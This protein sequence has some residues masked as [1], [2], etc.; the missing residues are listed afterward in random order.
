MSRFFWLPP[1]VWLLGRLWSWRGAYFNELVFG[2]VEYSLNALDT[3]NIIIH[4]S[5]RL[6]INR[7]M[8][9][10][11]SLHWALFQVK[12]VGP[13]AFWIIYI[14]TSSLRKW[15]VCC[16]L[17]WVDLSSR[18]LDDCKFSKRML[19]LE[20]LFLLQLFASE[21][22]HFDLFKV[23]LFFFIVIDFGLINWISFKIIAEWFKCSW[24]VSAF[25]RR[26]PG[27]LFFIIKI[28]VS[29]LLDLAL[30]ID[31]D[32]LR[33]GSLGVHNRFLLLFTIVVLVWLLHHYIF[34][35]FFRQFRV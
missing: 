13:F 28:R 14:Y 33:M 30:F 27:L 34:R 21:R 31:F 32:Q 20:H 9:T 11:V 18:V 8:S 16:N 17:S 6:R 26:S 19:S 15:R 25:L 7:R 1:R 29:H 10:T 24:L 12:W 3:L 35:F 4:V 2:F 23:H 5:K 22:L